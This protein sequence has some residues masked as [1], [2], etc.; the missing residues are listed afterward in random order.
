MN[1]NRMAMV[2][3][4][5]P[6]GLINKLDELVGEGYYLSRSE[7]I[8]AAVKDLVRYHLQSTPRRLKFHNQS[9]S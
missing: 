4:L 1:R 7:A 5:M 8:R 2:S 6:K 9:F 3:L